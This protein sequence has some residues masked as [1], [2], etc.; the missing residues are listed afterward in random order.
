MTELDFT[1]AVARLAE[2]TPGTE[3][4]P[5]DHCRVLTRVEL[6][7]EADARLWPM[8]EL[9]EECDEMLRGDLADEAVGRQ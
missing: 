4:R 8:N 7:V 1:A 6:L 5:C 9:C 2:L 3:D